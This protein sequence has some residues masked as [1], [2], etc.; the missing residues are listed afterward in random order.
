MALGN[1]WH[2]PG[3]PEPIGQAGMRDPVFPADPT[4][5]VTVFSGNQYRGDGNPGNQLQDGSA[6]R[7]RTASDA[8]WTTVPLLFAS[9]AGDNQYYSA[10][11]PA[12]PAGTVV[13][14]YLVIAYDDHDT[15]F[16]GADASGL[17]TVATGDEAAARAAPFGFTVETPG[18]DPVP[19]GPAAGRP[20]PGRPASAGLSPGARLLLSRPA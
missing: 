1:A 15:T 19:G 9:A 4:A 18:A 20:V 2:L 6:V 8:G 14:Y 10:A 3:N 5:P 16:L 12:F 7:F 11:L 17:L 13:Q